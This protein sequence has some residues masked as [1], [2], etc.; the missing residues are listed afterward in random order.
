MTMFE[1]ILEGCT[2]K[3]GTY[4]VRERQQSGSS[5]N[6]EGKGEADLSVN[7]L[8]DMFTTEVRQTIVS[9]KTTLPKQTSK[10]YC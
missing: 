9:T 1:D 7:E 4:T 5:G 10:T 6:V 3:Q 2:R 8:F